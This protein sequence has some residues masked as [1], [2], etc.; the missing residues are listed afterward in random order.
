MVKAILFDLQGTLLEN[1][2]YPSPVKQARYILG[3]RQG[4]HEYVPLFERAFMTQKF[5]NLTE[6]FKS[7]CESFQVYPPDFV[8]EKLVGVWNKNKLLSKLFPETLEVLKDLKKK[9][10]LVLIAN[11]DCFT[12]EVID[13]YALAQY[14]DEIFLSCDTG[15][16]KTDKDFFDVVLKKLDM[17]KEDVLVVGDSIESDIRSA[18]TYGVPCILIDRNNR[19]EFDNKISTLLGV[20]DYAESLE[21]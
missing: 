6:G 16:L 21:K 5:E 20:R 18:D 1:G 17:D 14:F 9:Y 7:V 3:I 12:K 4:F 10:K 15:M 8:L 19:M 11:I 2:I 13:K